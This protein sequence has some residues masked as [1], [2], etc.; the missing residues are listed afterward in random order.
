MLEMP[1]DCLEKPKW[2]EEKILLAPA[3]GKLPFTELVF[4]TFE[5]LT[6]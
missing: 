6:R 1:A 5:Q 3:G 2:E 4:P